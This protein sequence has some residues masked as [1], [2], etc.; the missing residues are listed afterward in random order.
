M[1]K[2]YPRELEIGLRAAVRAWPALV[3]TGPR[4]CGK[5]FSLRRTFPSASYHLLEDPDI[6]ARASADPRAWLA[7]VQTPAILDEIQNVPELLAYVRTRID[8]RPKAMGRWL[9][10]GSQDFALMQGVTESMAGRAATF[11]MLPLSIRELGTWDLVRGGYPE[12]WTRPKQSALWFR[13]YVET[14][15]ERDVRSITAVRDLSTFRRF[16]A[17][18]ATRN[19]T[20]LNKTDLSAPLGVSVPT[21][22]QWLSVLETTGIVAL[23]PP[24]YENLGKR[25]VKTPKLYWT[26]TGLLAFLL[27]FETRRDLERSPHVGAVFEAFVASEIIKRQLAR[28]RTR[29]LYWFRDHQG[30]EVDFVVP[31]RAGSI[32]LVEVKWTRT[33]VPGMANGIRALLPRFG[34]RKVRGWLVYRGAPDLAPEVALAPGVRAVSVDHFLSR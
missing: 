34:A 22:T 27:G 18:V 6:R 9:I 13:S 10:T 26:D 21:I 23:V 11:H 15:L 25:I 24:W 8:A 32:D 14:Y 31:E 3:V 1:A 33:P 17:L 5:T 20:M 28:G 19:A 29:E 30:L 16:L 12:V 2:V 4:R 7:D